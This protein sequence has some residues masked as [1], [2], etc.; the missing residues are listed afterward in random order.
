MAT[1]TGRAT[2][3]LKSSGA[4]LAS[5]SLNFTPG[6][7][8]LVAGAYDDAQGHPVSSKWG[9]R[10]LANRPA[11]ATRDPAA[12][13][14]AG[15]LWLL[16]RIKRSSSHVVTK[17]WGSAITERAMLIGEVAG[18]NRIDL[19]A[20]NNDDVATANPVTGTTGTLSAAD[21]FAIAYFVSQG[22]SGDTPGNMQILD[23]GTWT[24]V[25]GTQRIGTVGTPPLSNV[26]IHAGWL[27]L[28]SSQATQGRIQTATSRLWI[29]AIVTLKHADDLAKG[30]TT[31]D[32][33]DV[34]LI[35]E[36]AGLDPEDAAYC[37][38][39]VDDEWEVF[40]QAD[41]A[42]RVAHNIAGTGWTA[43]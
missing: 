34:E 40:D 4:T 35:F 9:N 27:Q 36:D 12:Y 17:T 22:P 25:T 26:T 3:S 20:G 15:S 43:D 21:D 13:D 23:G 19:S 8:L 11:S 18:K 42:T 14:I 6:N 37:Y 31:T 33:N 38:N 24:N 10:L 32:M 39:P 28:T 7:M 2:V 1:Y 16:P 5:G 30:I 29:S 41:M